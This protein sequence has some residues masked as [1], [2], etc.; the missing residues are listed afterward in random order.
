MGEGSKGL[1]DFEKWIQK[2]TNWFFKEDI[3]SLI[4]PKTEWEKQWSAKFRRKF[5]KLSNI[6]KT[7]IFIT[8]SPDKLHRNMLPTKENCEAVDK[9]C[10]SWFH[11]NPKFYGDYFYVLEGG[12]NNNHLHVHV[13]VESIN[14]H[15][16]AEKLKSSWKKSFPNHSLINSLSLNKNPGGKGGE[17]CSFHFNDPDI[18]K[19][20]IDYLHNDRKGDHMNEVD[21]G[22]AGRRGFSEFFPI[23]NSENPRCVNSRNMSED[24]NCKSPVGA[25]RVADEIAEEALAWKLICDE[26]REE[27]RLATQVKGGFNTDKFIKPPTTS[28]KVEEILY[29]L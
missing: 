25:L 28:K 18:L 14:S 12:S 2:K 11:Y 21:L 15:K 16:A 8:I 26:E 13:L 27:E 6:S 9:W 4:N 20:K 3:K 10:K 17:Y 22:Y 29:C 24:S 5:N 1:D 7:W 23:E 19:D